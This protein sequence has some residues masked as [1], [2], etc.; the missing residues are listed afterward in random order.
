ML[1]KESAFYEAH[2]AELRYKY[3]GKRV[4]IADNQILGIYGSDR[5]AYDETLKTRARKSFMIK[6]IPVNPDDEIDYIY[7]PVFETAHE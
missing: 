7:S 3:A 6:Y 4:V 2:K 5:E 1:E